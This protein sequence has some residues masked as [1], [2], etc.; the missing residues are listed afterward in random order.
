[1][2]GS[3]LDRNQD[4]EAGEAGLL[5]H[6]KARLL[7]AGEQ[8]GPGVDHVAPGQLVPLG[9]QVGTIQ[10]VNRA[11]KLSCFSTAGGCATSSRRHERS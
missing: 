6:L 2:I 1:M 10:S 3:G 7:A 8:R 4:A 11:R 9:E 5:G